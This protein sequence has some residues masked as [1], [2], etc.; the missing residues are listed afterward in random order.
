MENRDFKKYESMGLIQLLEKG[1]EQAGKFGRLE[2][3]IKMRDYA[4]E[5]LRKE[6]GKACMDALDDILP[7]FVGIIGELKREL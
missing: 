1:K 4:L 6:D 2:R 7:Y 3:M 5:S